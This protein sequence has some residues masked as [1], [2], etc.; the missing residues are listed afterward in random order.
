MSDGRKTED[1]TAETKDRINARSRGHFHNENESGLGS[2]PT[3]GYNGVVIGS[4]HNKQ[5]A[6]K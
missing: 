4:P 2:T 3:Q 5:S 1:Q 6:N